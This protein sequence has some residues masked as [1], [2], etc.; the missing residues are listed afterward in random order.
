MGV[1]YQTPRVTSLVGMFGKLCNACISLVQNLKIG[2][3]GIVSSIKRK[4]YILLK[5]KS[6]SDTISAKEQTF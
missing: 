3:L 6:L 2:S 1:I 5:S 4:P